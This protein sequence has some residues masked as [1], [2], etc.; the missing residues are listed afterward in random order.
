MNG[1]NK[2]KRPLWKTITTII[3]FLVIFAITITAA[4]AATV[5]ISPSNPTTYDPL[6]CDVAGTNAQ[7]NYYWYNGNTKVYQ[8]TGA[9]STLVT[10]Y[11]KPGDSITCK[12]Y[13]PSSS[14]Y[15]ETFVGQTSVAIKSSVIPPI[16]ANWLPSMN[17]PDVNIDEDSGYNSGLIDLWPYTS[18]DSPDNQLIFTIASESNTG[19][20]DCSVRSNR[21]IDCTTKQANSVGYSDVKVKVTDPNGAYVYDTSRI[22][23]DE[24]NDK[25]VFSNLGYKFVTED[26]G[27][28]DNMIDLKSFVY[29]PDTAT[30]KFTMQVFSIMSQSKSQVVNCVIDSNRYIDC[31]TQQDEYG[32][33][34]VVVSVWD[35]QYTAT[36]T[37]RVDVGPVNDA[38]V[39]SILPDETILEDSGLNRLSYLPDYSSDVDN[40]K[41]QLRY[42]VVANTNPALASCAIRTDNYLYCT[43]GKDMTGANMISVKVED[44]AGL[45]F[46]QFFR[47]TVEEVN[48]APV[49]NQ[50]P[51]QYLYE[52]SGLNPN[53]ID[54]QNYVSDIDT[55]LSQLKF[56][57]SQHTN[58]NIVECT[59]SKNRYIDCMTKADQFG[60]AHVEV[61]VNDGHLRAYSSFLVRVYRVAECSDGI[62]ND[63]D[64]FI[65]MNDPGCSSSTDDDEGDNPNVGPTI[66]NP[67]NVHINEDS[68]MNKK[69]ID[70]YK[71]TSDPDTQLDQL[72]F[73]ITKQTNNAIIDCTVDNDRYV[74]CKTVKQ[75]GTGNGEVTVEVS[76]GQYTATTDFKVSVDPVNDCPIIDSL[77]DVI[78]TEGDLVSLT[79]TGTD[80]DGDSLVSTCTNPLDT[81]C[82]WQTKTGDTGI[83]Y[84]TASVS[85]G[86]KMVC[87]LASQQ[88]KIT[89][90]QPVVLPQCSD[91]KDNDNDG[92]IDMNDPG[93]S[94]PSDNDET[95]PTP[96]AQCKD[97]IDNDND[98]WIDFPNDPGCSSLDDNTEGPNPQCSDGLDNDGDN[99]IDQNDPGCANKYDDDETDPVVLPQC[100][101]GKD[102]DN[103]GLIDM[104][105]PGCSSP[106]DDDET[107]PT[108][109]K[110]C[111][112][113]IDNDGD[114]KID[115][116]DPG[117]SSSTDNDESNQNSNSNPVVNTQHTNLFVKWFAFVDGDTLGTRYCDGD[118]SKYDLGA[119]IKLDSTG[120][121][122][123]STLSNT[124]KIN[125][126]LENIDKKTVED[127]VITVDV[128]GLELR[129]TTSRFDLKP[130]NVV[131][132]QISFDIP[133]NT[134]AG[135][136]E[137]RIEIM[138]EKQ[139]DKRRVIYRD[140]VISQPSLQK[141]V[142]T[143]EYVV[144][145]ETQEVTTAAPEALDI[146]Q[147][148]F[149]Q[150]IIDSI[151]AFFA[152][153]GAF[154]TQR[155]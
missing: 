128:P 86:N 108:I 45:S 11:T 133:S 44:P 151:L 124:I 46:I 76:D 125:I 14:Y 114:G 33:S 65:D 20:V 21:Y 28:H 147:K 81:N 93:C 15:P 23:V 41:S 73:K 106:S 54:L 66:T 95:D 104:N 5:T 10:S 69:V 134:K 71:Y 116:N 129:K 59:I 132:K 50:L 143:V 70:L 100:S 87:P 121:A 127:I 31:T 103:D 34:D 117:C 6:I 24:V 80:V 16:I 43:P 39:M 130:G 94:D 49:M 40:A 13:V 30:Q 126:G 51:N 99:L 7:F 101:D 38:P 27:F 35:G 29:D 56:V 144:L 96:L 107:D 9:S 153:L 22:T 91:G 138:S 78:V 60:D 64:G 42:S 63:N 83:Y 88:V 67:N 77:N 19:L 36:S 112:D 72:T 136:Y 102:N 12:A 62:D 89:V 146:T 55:P 111:A 84:V 154:L 3:G 2:M 82:K 90:N 150:L 142:H 110:Q 74:D 4:M 68:G 47:L 52:N 92:L 109:P 152:N 53:L 8:N 79:V 139:Q 17:L 149:I 118:L 131:S 115:M 48:D 25:P 75:D 105:D 120:C 140:I 97:G 32:F 119:N 155:V 135:T 98:G 85:D 61:S 145:D 1:D 148:S 57:V 58:M 18:D 26:S 123:D 137:V 37:L 122:Y 113:G 141:R